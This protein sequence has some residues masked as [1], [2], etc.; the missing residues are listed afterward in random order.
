MPTLSALSIDH[1]VAKLAAPFS[2]SSTVVLGDDSHCTVTSSIDP[3][4][5]GPFHQC[6]FFL[7]VIFVPLT[8]ESRKYAPVPALLLANQA[9]A[10]GS[11]AVLWVSMACL[12]IIGNMVM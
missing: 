2:I 4:S 3:G 11:L 12:L 8:H 10:Q 6:G 7:S 9:F 5:H 1:S